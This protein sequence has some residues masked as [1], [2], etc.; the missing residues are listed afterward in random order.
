VRIFSA[1]CNILFLLYLPYG[2][3][4]LLKARAAAVPKWLVLV[5]IVSQPTPPMIEAPIDINSR[6]LGFRSQ[7]FSKP[8]LLDIWSA[9]MG[10]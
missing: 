3:K 5:K 4:S 2:R 8:C 10:M 6:P 9:P 7:F 1:T